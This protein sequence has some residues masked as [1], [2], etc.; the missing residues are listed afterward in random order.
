MSAKPRNRID[1]VTDRLVRADIQQCDHRFAA[2]VTDF[3]RYCF[4]A[5]AQAVIGDDD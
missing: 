5:L 4:G 3:R 2:A 1:S